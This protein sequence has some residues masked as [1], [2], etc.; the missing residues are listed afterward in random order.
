LK[1]RAFRRACAGDRS[2]MQLVRMYL[3]LFQHVVCQTAQEGQRGGTRRTI[4]CDE[5]RYHIPQTSFGP[6][7]GNDCSAGEFLREKNLCAASVEFEHMLRKSDRSP[8]V[9]T[10]LRSAAIRGDSTSSEIENTS[11]AVRSRL[12]ILF[13]FS[14]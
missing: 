2:G 7:N 3:L 5:K 11:Q 10:P 12:I 4:A 1:G 13:C 14:I 8:S 6:S 9:C